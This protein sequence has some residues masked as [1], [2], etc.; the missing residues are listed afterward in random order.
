MTDLLSNLPPISAP[1]GNLA[2][3]TVSQLAGSIRTTLERA[4][5]RVRVRGELGRVTRH[6]NGHTYLD[7]KDDQACI[8]GVI[9]RMTAQR[10]RVK[11]EE[12]LEV[13]ATGRLTTF[14]PRS[15][16]QLIIE[17]LELAGAGA[18]MALL[19]KRKKELA[20]QGL[21]DPAR[22]KKLPFLPE[23]IGVITSPTGA[24][25][26]D[27][28]HRLRDRFPRRVILW[29]V[30][31]QGER[32]APEIAAAIAGFNRLGAGGAIPRPDLI[33]VARGGGSI[34]DLWAFNEEIVVRA[35]AA[36]AIPLISAVGHET[37]TTLI[38]YASDRRAPTPTAAAEI[39]V[40]VR[41]ELISEVLDYDRRQRLAMQRLIGERKRTLEGLVRGLP[42]G[43]DLLLPAHQ[44][45]D[46]LSHRLPRAL[47]A[48]A[49]TAEARLN[50]V[51]GRVQPSVLTNVVRAHR[52]ALQQ[53]GERLA[54]AFERQ[55]REQRSS[56]LRGRA[57]LIN[58]ST[59]MSTV[60]KLRVTRLRS[61]LD[62]VA[63]LMEGMSFERT[64]ERGYAVVSDGS[65]TLIRDSAAAAAAREVEL[66]FKGDDRVRAQ[67]AG[68]AAEVKKPKEKKKAAAALMTEPPRQ[69]RLF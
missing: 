30:V 2:E 68:V 14:A 13:V 3:M 53:T 35:A 37:D 24:V 64:L 8:N 36:S 33:I 56:L 45:L 7:L 42:R 23:V 46:M 59:R 57:R 4:F 12:G 47:R 10:I 9:F 49:A 20:A 58:A 54:R 38:D 15:A 19:E 41:S 52:R 17:D 5:D 6:A 22:K 16:Y 11:P 43:E 21:F 28:M 32:A 27:I 1:P 40:P 25:I 62:A 39:A 34:E 63:R 60:Q 29:P 66:R 67:V 50:R 44:R 31:V 26:R 51:S 55:L 48:K 69:G 18:L 61:R 65:G